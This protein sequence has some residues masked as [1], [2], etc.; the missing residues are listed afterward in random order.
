MARTG[1]PSLWISWNQSSVLRR[2]HR[3]TPRQ[4]LTITET[5]NL[6]FGKWMLSAGHSRGA[7]H[8]YDHGIHAPRRANDGNALRFCGPR[9]NDLLD[10]TRWLH[11]TPARRNAQ[12]E[13]RPAGNL[14]GLGRYE[15]GRGSDERRTSPDR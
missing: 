15:A 1:D 14:W 12:H 5:R 13:I 8:R 9:D 6:P 11:G 4:E 7:K 10:A 3:T 2:A